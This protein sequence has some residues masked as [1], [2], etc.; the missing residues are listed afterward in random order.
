MYATGQIV[1]LLGPPGS[2]KGTQASRLSAAL[3]IPSISTGEMLRR[4]CLSGSP[5]GQAIKTVLDSGKL[6]SD[7]LINQVVASRL[8]ECDC[9]DGCILDGY[10]RTVS[11]AR[12]LDDLLISRNMPAPIV[13]DFEIECEEILARLS[14]RQRADDTPATI[15]ERLRVYEQNA[16]E[17]VRYYSGE[18]LYRIQAARAPEAITEE[19]LRILD[20]SNSLRSSSQAAQFV[21]RNYKTLYAAANVS[22]SV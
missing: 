10:P 12:F 19:L 8:A 4:E 2:G 9:E 13:F 20:E 15:C 5:L 21:V 22:R 11:Q 14:R 18:S 17:L 6:V 7:E 16:A 3:A 1:V